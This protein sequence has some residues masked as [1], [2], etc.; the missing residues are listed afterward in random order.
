MAFSFSS[1]SGYLCDVGLKNF[2]IFIVH[3]SLES[4]QK[5]KCGF[6]YYQHKLMAKAIGVEGCLQNIAIFDV[7]KEERNPDKIF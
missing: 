2:Q 1:D 7:K 6:M 3:T 5:Q 4:D